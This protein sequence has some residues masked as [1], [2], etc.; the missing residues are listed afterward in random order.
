[1]H[2]AYITH[3]EFLKHDMGPEH[4]E[5]PARIHAVADQLI[6]SGLFDFLSH[7]EAPKVSK[8]V[9]ALAH[10]QAYIDWVF[11]LSPTT[12]LADLDGDTLM[13][14]YTLDAALYATGAVVKAVDLVM[15]NEV[16][17][18]FCN[19]RPPGIMLSGLGHQAFVFLT[20][21]QL[22]LLMRLSITVCNALLLPTL[23]YIMV[24]ALK[25]FFMMTHALWFAQLFSTHITLIAAR[26]LVMTI[27]SMY[28]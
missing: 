9:L 24:M 26:I 7:Y 3:P 1:M 10:T 17:N 21:W 23:T 28:H 18:A 13:N 4:P 22:Q 14:P 6:A 12:G 5:C 16:Q 11:S 15:A 20:M 27:L 8:E 2:T 19:I 25:T